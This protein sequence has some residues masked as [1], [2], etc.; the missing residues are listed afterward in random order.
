MRAGATAS[1]RLLHLG[2]GSAHV[3]AGAEVSADIDHVG[4]LRCSTSN[5]RCHGCVIGPVNTNH[6]D[7]CRLIGLRRLYPVRRHTH[8]ED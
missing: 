2:P 4:A 3:I 6:S 1:S 5:A 8:D 7:D